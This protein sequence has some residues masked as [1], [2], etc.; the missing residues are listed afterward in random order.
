MSIEGEPQLPRV[1]EVDFLGEMMTEEI[2]DETKK[3]VDNLRRD[4]KPLFDQVRLRA[5]VI[6]QEHESTLDTQIDIILLVAFVMRALQE[7]MKRER[8]IN[9]DSRIDPLAPQ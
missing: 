9:D 8:E 2:F 3:W 1:E 6:A 5:F 4:N 7:A